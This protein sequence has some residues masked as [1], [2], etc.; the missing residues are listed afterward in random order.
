MLD[1]LLAYGHSYKVSICALLR[2]TSA[3]NTKF[4]LTRVNTSVKG[5]KGHSNPAV[6]VF[7][8]NIVQ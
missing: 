5:G 4:T 6:P 3:I 7:I 8:T 2:L 1:E